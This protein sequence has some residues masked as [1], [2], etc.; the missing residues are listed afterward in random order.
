MSAYKKYHIF[1][2]FLTGI[3][4]KPEAENGVESKTGLLKSKKRF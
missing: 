4:K 2:T 3:Q 1:P